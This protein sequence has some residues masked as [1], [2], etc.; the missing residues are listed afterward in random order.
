M[1]RL[2]Q[3]TAGFDEATGTLSLNHPDLGET[4]IRPDAEGA[5]LCDWIAPLAE[6]TTRSGPFQICQAPG[7]AFTDFEDT[8][9]S[10]ASMSSLRA[11][12]EMAGQRLELVRFR[13]NIWL[14]GLAPWEELDWV[15]R[16]I[17]L[18][19]TRVK[20][21]ARDKRCN[22]TTA[23]P[24]TGQRDAQVPALL[25]SRFGHMDFGVYGQ[26]VSGGVLRVGDPVSS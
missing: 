8:H 23:S 18:G 13:M 5:A 17:S 4:R 9:L 24:L 15:G 7:V 1:P 11:L 14:E 19:E 10:I 22:A 3:L 12:E 21:T 26:V 6:G 16:E 25:Q 2:A 20:I